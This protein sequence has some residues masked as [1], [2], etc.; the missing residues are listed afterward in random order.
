MEAVDQHPN[1]AAAVSNLRSKAELRVLG[2]PQKDEREKGFREVKKIFR[3]IA[4]LSSSGLQDVRCCT[5][6]GG[7]GDNVCAHSHQI[8]VEA[9]ACASGFAALA[10]TRTNLRDWWQNVM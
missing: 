5:A 9:H 2:L 6:V 8:I 7:N 3:G 10:S 4:K 1:G